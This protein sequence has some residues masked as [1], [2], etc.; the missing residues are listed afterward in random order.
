VTDRSTLAS[1]A[2]AFFIG[3][4]ATPS[5]YVRFIKPVSFALILGAL[6]VGAVL[7]LSQSDSGAGQWDNSN[8]V[9]LRGL[10]FAKPYAMLRIPGEEPGKSPRTYLLVEDGKFGALPRVARFV[11][12]RPDGAPVEVNG[13]VL[14][15]GDRWML[16]LEEGDR[17]MRRLPEE[18]AKKLPDLCWSAPKVLAESVTLHGEII[19]SKCYLGAMS[20]G[21]GKT[22]KACAMRCIAGGV[23]P[24]LVTRNAA[25]RERFFLLV[26]TDGRGAN[27]AVFPYV[28]D[29]VQVHGRL[30]LHDDL[31]V[32]LTN[33]ERI[34]R[35]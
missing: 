14:H 35:Q 28:G 6:A 5:S 27:E 18:E 10:A 15:R 33:T 19:D 11:Q 17:G 32:F 22:H 16:A 3:W 9:T 13:T 4:E 12:D 30:E 23:P 20:P 1:N 25:K 7:A 34:S 29:Q 24:M 31:L 21:G 8:V 26:T 2:D